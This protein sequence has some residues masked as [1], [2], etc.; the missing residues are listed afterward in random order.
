MNSASVNGEKLFCQSSEPHSHSE[1]YHKRPSTSGQFRYAF[2]VNNNSNVNNNNK[3][4]RNYVVPVSESGD[5]NDDKGGYTVPLGHIWDAYYE[6]IKNK[7]RTVNAMM[8]N[9]YL[10]RNITAL[11]KDINNKTYKIGRSIAFIVEHPVKREVFAADFRDRIVHDWICMRLNPLFEDYLPEN[12]ASNRV[13]KGTLYAIRKAYDLIFEK[14]NGYTEDCWI[15]KFDLQ[16]FFMSI[17]KVLLNKKLQAFIDE[18]YQ[19]KDIDILKW[20]TEKVIMNCPQKNCY[21]KSPLSSWAGLKANKSLFFQDDFHGM[22]IGNLPSQLF[23]NFLLSDMVRFLAKHGFDCVQYVDDVVV[24]HKDKSDILA[25][26][27]ILR[28]WLQETL[29][30]TLH[31]KKCYIQHYSKGVSFVGGIIKPHRIYLSKRSR[32]RAF[33]KTHWIVLSGEDLK[34]AMPSVNSYL[35]LTRHYSAYKIRK[36]LAEML[37]SQY[38]NSIY[39]NENYNTLKITK[40]GSNC[41]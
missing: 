41:R 21:R 16:G 31:P 36:S 25:F 29:G 27:P 12:M 28:R 22:P 15:W 17:N 8:F 2:N 40:N 33:G 37:F 18:R 7:G 34:K 30:I 24:V 14:S 3:Y 10:E 19:E 6:C 38:G 4:N 35:G 11:W 23:A 26:I 20:L 9:L 5:K 39:F 13:G 32:R 1:L